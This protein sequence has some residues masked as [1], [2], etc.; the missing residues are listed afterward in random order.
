MMANGGKHVDFSLQNQIFNSYATS[1]YEL[2]ATQMV[3][4]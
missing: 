3:L 2:L 1:F 4:V